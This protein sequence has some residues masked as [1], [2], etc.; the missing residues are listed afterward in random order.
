MPLSR[1]RLEKI[2]LRAD[3]FARWGPVLHRIIL[4]LFII[5]FLLVAIRLFVPSI[6]PEARWPEGVLLVLATASI[7]SST[8]LQLPGQN[9][10]LAGVIIAFIG[11]LS[12]TIGALTSIPFGPYS[13]TNRIPI[14]FPPLPWAVPVLWL[15]I[16]LMSRGVG[17]LILRPWRKTR[18]Y[19]FWLIGITTGL[20]LLFDLGLEPFAAQVKH[21]WLWQP[22]HAL[23]YWYKTPWVNFIGWAAT[24]L[25]ILGFATPSL[26]NKKPVKHPP[27]YWPLILWG[28]LSAL[29][30]M[31]A[32]TNQLWL[33]AGIVGIST[34]VV[35]IFA[36]KGARW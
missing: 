12:H 6:L 22:S 29:F 8:A 23:L 33:A 18:N 10:M 32:I 31:A 28:L 15:L 1:R 2:P 34:V 25:V 14:L 26:I 36:I 24:T 21:Y 19:G 3:P 30:V 20:V 27:E 13:Y 17:R 5:Q 7:I 4:I 16:I 35:A 9:V 11:G